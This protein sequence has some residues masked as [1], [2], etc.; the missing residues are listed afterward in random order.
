MKFGN[1]STQ[2]IS[3]LVV[4]PL[5]QL[6]KL[7]KK[8]D[9]TGMLAVYSQGGQEGW[10]FPRE[11]LYKGHKWVTSACQWWYCGVPPTEMDSD[12]RSQ[13]KE[14]G[15]WRPAK[16]FPTLTGGWDAAGAA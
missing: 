6:F 14:R 2:Q 5:F 11:L 7:K 15:N 16:R 3:S 13:E 12:N 9:A 10:R 8:Q 1:S 4:H